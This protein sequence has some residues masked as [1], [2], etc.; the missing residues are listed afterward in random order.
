MFTKR[1]GGGADQVVIDIH[2]GG[3]ACDNGL[4]G[5]E[6]DG[7]ERSAIGVYTCEIGQSQSMRRCPAMRPV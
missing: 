4:A 3:T 7:G 1:D 5:M 6:M 2:V